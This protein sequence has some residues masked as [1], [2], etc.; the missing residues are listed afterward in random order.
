MFFA[1]QLDRGNIAQA[2]SD[3]MLTDLNLSTDEYN[4]G[5]TIFYCSFLFAELPSQMI[6]KRIGP[7]TWI[8]T[9]MVLWSLVAAF[10]SLITGRNSFW[11]TRALLGLLEGGFIPDNIVSPREC[12][13]FSEMLTL[14][15]CT[16]ATG[17]LPVNF[18]NDFLSS[19]LPIS[20]HKSFLL[21]SPM[22][23]STYGASNFRMVT[24]PAGAGYF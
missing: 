3:N 6:G 4:Y 7:D 23:S 8:P 18:Q 12:I 21:S 14:G 20:Q 22:A 24:P 2:L 16:L 1:L 5:Q 9:Q 17:T 11:I 13:Q 10:Q 15:S 19:G